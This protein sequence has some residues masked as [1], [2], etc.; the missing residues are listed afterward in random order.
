[1][2]QACLSLLALAFIAAAGTAKAQ[3]GFGRPTVGIFGGVSL[4]SSDFN[5]EVGTGWHAGGLVKMRAYKALDVRADGTF[6]KFA[7]KDIVGTVAT[8]E[9]Y[10]TVIHGNLDLLLNLGTDSAAYPGDNSVSPYILGG[11]G[12][13]HLDYKAECTGTCENFEAPSR[14][15]FGLN[16]GGGATFPLMGLRTFVEGRYHRISR[17]VS[18]GSSRKMILISAGIKFR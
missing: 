12:T 2:K 7:S 1:M 17:S 13:Y 8:V 5:D 6:N 18:Q 3:N 10:A 16:I 14:N 11:I 4:P 9:T 15:H